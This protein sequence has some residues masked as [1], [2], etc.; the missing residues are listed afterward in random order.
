MRVLDKNFTYRQLHRS[1]RDSC[2]LH[3]CFA[4]R[5]HVLTFLGEAL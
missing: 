1:I 4:E 2:E 5:E 3:K